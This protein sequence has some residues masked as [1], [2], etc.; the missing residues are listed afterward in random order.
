MDPFHEHLAQVALHAA[1]DLGFALADGY[2][3]QAHGFLT[4]PSEDV[5]LFT[6]AERSDFDWTG[7]DWT[8]AVADAVARYDARPWRMGL[9]DYD[10]ALAAGPSACRSTPSGTHR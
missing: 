1:S 7:L 10:A 6:S 3:I 5:D 9:A 4:R 8:Q 2:A